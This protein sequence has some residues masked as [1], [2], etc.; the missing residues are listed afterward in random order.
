MATLS[1]QVADQLRDEIASG[2]WPVGGRIPGE[3]ELVR[4]LGVSRNTVR[5]AVRSLVHLGLLEPRAG[6]GTYVRLTSELE[7]VLVRRAS[8]TRS[9]DVLEL[10]AVLEEHAAGL[11]AE[12]RTDADVTRLREL[13]RRAHETDHAEMTA[14][15]DAD[16]AFH[17][18]VVEVGGN[19]LLAEVYRH[20]GSALAAVVAELAW[21][22]DLAARHNHWHTA[23]VDAIE[24]GD[25][26]SARL[27]AATLVQ[28]TRRAGEG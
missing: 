16:N 14:L 28:L 17:L 10:R 12:R 6:D 9:C 18:A 26:V 25:P 7:A 19:E 4:I 20:L 8:T 13:L 24:A 22:E 15:A 11:A 3:H 1:A 2:R 21:D 27:A 23:L 5:E